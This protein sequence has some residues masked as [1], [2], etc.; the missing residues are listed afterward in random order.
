MVERLREYRAGYARWITRVMPAPQAVLRGGL[1]LVI[2]MAGLH[3]LLAPTVWTKY[4]A[5]PVEAM[6]P[7]AVISFEQ[8]MVLNG[9]LE[10]LFGVV[11]LWGVLTSVV[12]GI[13]FLSLL[14]VVANLALV[15][16]T[17][18]Q[19]VDILIRDLGLTA[20]ALGVT[21]QSAT[22]AVGNGTTLKR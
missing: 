11:L 10:V 4:A 20:L 22:A 8:A 17:T 2:G 1:G 15:A 12:A 6:W 13:V 9:V 5:P 7:S 21:I 18:G 14:G 19:Y 3:K 16:V